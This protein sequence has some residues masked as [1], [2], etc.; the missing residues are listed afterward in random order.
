MARLSWLGLILT[1]KLV[2]ILLQLLSSPF[3]DLLK[4]RVAEDDSLKPD[5]FKLYPLA[6]VASRIFPLKILW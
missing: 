4:K 2:H 3:E 5:D 6:N 1:Y